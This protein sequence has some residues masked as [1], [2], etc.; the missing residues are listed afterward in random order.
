MPRSFPWNTCLYDHVPFWN[1]FFV[2]LLFFFFFSSIL[3]LRFTQTLFNSIYLFSP[4]VL[5]VIW[6][7]WPHQAFGRHQTHTCVCPSGELTPLP[8]GL[9]WEYHSGNIFAMGICRRERSS[10]KEKMFWPRTKPEPPRTSV[11]NQVCTVNNLPQAFWC[12]C[13]LKM[14][15]RREKRALG[16]GWRSRARSFFLLFQHC[17]Q[18]LACIMQATFGPSW[19]G[20]PH[21]QGKK[22]EGQAVRL[23]VQGSF[24]RWICFL[25]SEILLKNTPSRPPLQWDF[26]SPG[27]SAHSP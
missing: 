23:K 16:G 7:N 12:R 4:G 24:R 6:Q 22:E 27:I 8:C 20:G 13:E 25:P 18:H 26:R 9:W 21:C 1:R 5:R 14:C 15:G 10:S 3:G 19:P 11:L 2:C 17:S